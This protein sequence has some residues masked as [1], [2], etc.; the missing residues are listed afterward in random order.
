LLPVLVRSRGGQRSLSGGSRIAKETLMPTRQNRRDFLASLSAA[1]AASLLGAPGSL[2][3]EGPLETTSVRLTT[4]A[5][6]CIAPQYL[7]G[8]LL[9]ADGFTDVG[10]VPAMKGPPGAAMIGRGEADFTSTFAGSVILPIDEGAQITALAGVHRGCYELFAHEGVGSIMDLKGK[11]ISVPALRSSPHLFLSAMARHIGL[12]P[13]QDIEWVVPPPGGNALEAFAEGK[14]DAFLGFPPEPQELRARGI[15]RVILNTGTERPWSQYFCCM[16]LGN[17]DY[18]SNYPVATKRVLRA[19]LKSIDHCAAE[20][21]RAAQQLIDGG[22]AD[23]L[24]YAEQTLTE[25]PFTAWREYDP[26]DTMR[27]Y[28]LRLR[29]VDMIKSTPNTILAQGTDWSFLNELKRELKA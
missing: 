29:E 12:D 16:L 6:I 13:R 14:T 9:R 28:A 24:D 17:R 26:A 23:R 4:A 5:G 10:F 20:P 19:V 22:F 2:A 11:R 7:A 21:L 18:V 1:G 3:A 25:V 8:E 27:F 15:G